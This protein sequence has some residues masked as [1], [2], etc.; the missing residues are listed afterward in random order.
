MPKHT[1]LVNIQLFKTHNYIFNKIRKIRYTQYTYIFNKKVT[2]KKDK[3]YTVLED[4]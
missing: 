2:T 4:V 3:I 1:I